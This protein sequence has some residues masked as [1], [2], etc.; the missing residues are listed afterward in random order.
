MN[1]VIPLVVEFARGSRV[2]AIEAPPSDTLP[3][4]TLVRFTDGRDLPI[5][6]DQIVH[7]DQGADSVRVGFGGMSFEGLV[8][9]QLAFWRVKDLAP[10]ELLRADRDIR[11]LIDPTLVSEVVVRGIRVWPS[12][13]AEAQIATA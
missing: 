3:K 1:E 12:K 10:E 5:P 4:D 2:E 6:A 13:V 9:G 8:D 11:F 7:E